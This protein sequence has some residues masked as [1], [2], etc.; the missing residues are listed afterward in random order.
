MRWG[1]V[2]F[3]AKDEKIGY[4]M[5]NARAETI[6]EK[7]AYRAAFK[8]RRA[9]IPAS[10]FYEWQKTADLKTPFNIKLVTAKY[11]S[12]AGLYESW[13]AHEGVDLQTFTII[14]KPANTAISKIHDRMPVILDTDEE[15]EWLKNDDPKFL[16]T[17]LRSELNAKLEIYPIS[18]AIN[19]PQNDYPGLVEKIMTK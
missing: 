10:N 1:L 5:I 7:P 4:K 16:Q 11:F 19:S 14:T 3:W 8:A 9:L 15:A 12:F 6:S 18:E 2:P 13:K 17:I